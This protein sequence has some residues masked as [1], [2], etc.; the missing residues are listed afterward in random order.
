MQFLIGAFCFAAYLSLIHEM[1][2]TDNLMGFLIGFFVPPI[3][4]IWGIYD[5][6][7]TPFI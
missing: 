4:V 6:L 1:Y 2:I 7:T 3:G 5:L